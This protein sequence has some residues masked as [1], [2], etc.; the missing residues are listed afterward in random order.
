MRLSSAERSD[1]ALGSLE[2][3][4]NERVAFDVLIRELDNSG[5]FNAG[6]DVF[7]VFNTSEMTVVGLLGVPSENHFR[8]A[9]EAGEDTEEHF[10]THLLDFIYQHEGTHEGAST[11]PAH[12]NELEFSFCE[13]LHEEW[14]TDELGEVI[15]DT[16]GEGG[17]FFEQ[18]TGESAEV[19]AEGGG[20]ATDDEDF[21]EPF[22]GE[23]L[24]GYG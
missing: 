10:R 20:N 1:P 9:T 4:T 11:A 8:A 19:F 18:V 21:I 16:T 2:D 3:L 6:G 5:A 7:S 17:E 13:V 23:H 24:E 22:F 15:E 14:A 12:G